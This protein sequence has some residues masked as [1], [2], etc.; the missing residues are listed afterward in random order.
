MVPGLI[1]LGAWTIFYPSPVADS[2]THLPFDFALEYL[3]RTPVI[4]M[5]GPELV[6]AAILGALLVGV[7]FYSKPVDGGRHSGIGRMLSLDSHTACGDFRAGLDLLHDPGAGRSYDLAE[8][9]V[10]SPCVGSCLSGLW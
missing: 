9:S 10:G 6:L 7:A 5:S 4:L 2:V 1:L 8:S 3:A